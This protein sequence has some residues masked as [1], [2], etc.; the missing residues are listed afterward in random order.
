M[1]VSDKRDIQNMQCWGYF[2]S[3]TGNH[4]FKILNT[5]TN[6]NR[7]KTLIH[8][9]M[10]IVICALGVHH[11]EKKHSFFCCSL[12][13]TLHKMDLHKYT[14]KPKKYINQGLFD[15]TKKKVQICIFT[16][17]VFISGPQCSHSCKVYLQP[18][19]NS[20]V[21]YFLVIELRSSALQ[22]KTAWHWGSTVNCNL[23]T[24]K[25]CILVPW[26]SIM[27]PCGTLQISQPQWKV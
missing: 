8:K 21:C 18:G 12:V 26:S 27:Y 15:P 25:R 6:T 14:V 7:V 23:S 19:S 13:P 22:G 1:G 4:W 16:A 20:P 11:C 3:R 2:M 17:G 10:A 24:P 9:Q 5:P